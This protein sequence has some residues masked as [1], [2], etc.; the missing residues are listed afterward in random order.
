MFHYVARII[1]HRKGFNHWRSIT[2]TVPASRK[3]RLIFEEGE[4]KISFEVEGIEWQEQSGGLVYLNLWWHP[5]MDDRV[6]ALISGDSR[7]HTE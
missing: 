4:S 5:A 1:N 6:K 3:M 7:W 2:L